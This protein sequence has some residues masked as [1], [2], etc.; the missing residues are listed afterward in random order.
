MRFGVALGRMHPSMFTDAVEAADALGFESVWFPEHLVL[1]VSM[2]GSPFAGAEHPP[3]PPSTPVF[4]VF[5]YLSFLA[6]RTRRVRLGTHVY[7]MALR[8]PFVAAR[9]VATLDVLSEGRVELGVGA[10]WL[11]A[12]WDAVGLDFDSR[13]ARLDEALEVCVALWRDEQVAYDGAFFS[14]GDVMFEPKPHQRPHP[15][16]SIGGESAVAL[17]RAARYDGWIGLNHT[18]ESVRRPVERLR[19][20]RAERTEQAA[21]VGQSNHFTVTVGASVGDDSDIEAFAA[22]GVDRL[23]VSPWA[24]TRDVPAA[25]EEF[26]R[27][28]L[29]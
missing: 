20:L 24:R 27:R 9:A 12:E 2:D 5:V 23:I 17:R 28:L 1:P 16:I 4:D 29:P 6:A 13:G 14:F 8:H 19:A 15:P 22:A 10:G 7:N 3:I 11:R 21:I 18:P 26:T 25:L